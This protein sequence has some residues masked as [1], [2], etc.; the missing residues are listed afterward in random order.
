MI[1]SPTTI[2]RL[3]RRDGVAFFGKCAR[4]AFSSHAWLWLLRGGRFR[5]EDQEQDIAL[6]RSSKWF[7]A[8]WYVREYP[9]ASRLGISPEAH[10]LREGTDGR[11]SPGPDFVADEYLAL[12]LDVAAIGVNPLLHYERGGNA[13]GRC[14]SFLET[15]C[16]YPEEAR[17]VRASFPL[18]PARLRRTAVFAAHSSDC[19]IPERTLFYLR[20]LADV[21]DNIVFVASNPL[22]PGEAEK[23]NGLVSDI[24]AEQHDEYDFGSYKRGFRLA[25][26]RKLLD[27]EA[28]DELILCNDSCYGPVFPFAEMFASMRRRD[29]DFW[30]MTA[31]EELG[32]KHLQSFFLVFRRRVLD[33]GE[34]ARFLDG[35]TALAGRG[36]V[37]LH[38]ETSLA[39]SLRKA[40]NRPDSFVPFGET[41]NETG[42]SPNP[43]LRPLTLLR[44]FK[45]PLVKVKALDG[46]I[47]EPLDETLA[48]LHNANSELSRLVV[49]RPRNGEAESS[50]KQEWLRALREGLPASFPK[51]AAA[52]QAK[53][54]RGEVVQCVFFV[55]SPDSFPAKDLFDALASGRARPFRAVAC[56]VPDRRT[57]NPDADMDACAAAMA[58]GLPK[59]STIRPKPN[60]DGAWPDVLA[61]ADIAVYPP[62]HSSFPFPYRPHWAVGRSFLPVL[63]T[64]GGDT[65]PYASLANCQSSMRICVGNRALLECAIACPRLNSDAT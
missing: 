10:Y 56:I 57:D 24:L 50:R 46:E 63:A 20:G 34:L 16:S 43:M 28:V 6:V 37:V 58:I 2:A 27:A 55:S 42:K 49:S 29:C 7:D 13:E 44:R 31:N 4:Y 26:G 38:Y 23:L 18:R 45:A 54:S 48:F 62:N 5:A 52:I 32:A 41:P 30:G 39:E 47:E 61:E 12:N 51:K 17:P 21:A 14:V 15:F 25:R 36:S 1:F 65:R 59:D 3:L 22:L 9:E 19:R 60:P 53:V 11:V 40:G 33:G 8:Q 64:A 35:V